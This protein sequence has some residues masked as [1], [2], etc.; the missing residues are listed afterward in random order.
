MSILRVNT[1]QD[2]TGSSPAFP[3]LKT[4]TIQT[5]SG[6]TALSINSSGIVLSPNRPAFTA[7]NANV[8]VFPSLN[9]IIILNTTILN[10]GNHYSTSTGNFTAPVSG[11]YYFSFTG[12]TEANASGTNN[13]EIRR[14]SVPIVR[15]YTN[16]PVNTH[17][18]FAT[19]CIISLETN[20]TVRPYSFIDIHS[21]Q[22]PVFT[23][24][25][26]G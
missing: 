19:E 18:P 2:L 13:I 12:F 21:N 20:D 23:G 26:L 5:I 15:T 22:N 1:L 11:L 4:N 17:R 16:E 14:N 3:I 8:N 9:G 25:L 6:N 10:N 7:L 24:F